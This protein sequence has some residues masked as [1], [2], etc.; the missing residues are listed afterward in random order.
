MKRVSSSQVLNA[1]SILLLAT[2]VIGVVILP[3]PL[4][5]DGGSH[6][7]NALVTRALLAGDTS[8]I[9]T[10]GLN[11]RLV[12]NWGIPSLLMILDGVTISAKAVTMLCII[13]M[14]T[15]FWYCARGWS[16]DRSW[17]PLALVSAN[18]W[19]LWMGFWGFCLATALSLACIGW[20]RRRWDAPTLLAGFVVAVWQLAIATFHPMPPLLVTLVVCVSLVLD[21]NDSSSWKK[22]V[23]LFVGSLVG[24]AGMS[25]VPAGFG[26]GASYFVTSLR[27]FA[28]S[29][30]L[31]PIDALET[32]RWP[33]ADGRYVVGMLAMVVLTALVASPRRELW[34]SPLLVAAG[35]LL[36]L[37][38]PVNDAQAGG[39]V[40]VPRLGYF[41][42]I[43]LL[44]W[45]WVRAGPSVRVVAGLG[46][47][48][49]VSLGTVLHFQA[50]QRASTAVEAVVNAGRAARLPKGAVLVRIR[51]PTWAADS[52]YGIRRLRLPYLLT[53]S[54]D[55]FAAEARVQ[56]LTNYEILG[57]NFVNRMQ[58]TV[59]ESEVIEAL[60]SLEEPSKTGHVTA[61][62]RIVEAI[63]P[64]SF[65]LI[66]DDPADEVRF[67]ESSGYQIVSMGGA[68]IFVRFLRRD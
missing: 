35:L 62:K 68:P 18:S 45:A 55:W 59:A 33:Y 7:Y 14:F 43:L 6:V 39:A 26:G 22:R 37:R 60:R 48:G 32:V 40:V 61:L 12:P 20:I 1:A 38:L 15:A 5:N 9:H 52:A 24:F 44:I 36:V 57:G 27:Q 17:G 50:S 23:P 41:A 29:V 64:E 42:W 31:F 54:V 10:A 51:T 53:H 21:S 3:Y 11:P 2:L 56:H 8:W 49:S 67:L 25:I 34:R 19:F 63:G 28:E 13:S 58:S 46:I 30:A 47:V 65:V 66:G 16:G 4:S